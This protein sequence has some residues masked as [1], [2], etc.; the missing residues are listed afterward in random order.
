MLRPS[1]KFSKTAATGMRVPRN[2][3][4]PLTFPGTLSTAGHFDQSSNIAAYCDFIPKKPREIQ[5]RRHSHL[6][7]ITWLSLSRNRPYVPDDGQGRRRGVK[8][9]SVL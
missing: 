4:E 2:T 1:S 6:V 8:S 9:R 7:S 3:H 5:I